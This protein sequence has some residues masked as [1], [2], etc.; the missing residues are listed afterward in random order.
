MI[1]RAPT[2]QLR[3]FTIYCSVCKKE[4]GIR[5]SENPSGPAKS[6]NGDDKLR[7]LAKETL[8]ERMRSLVDACSRAPQQPQPQQQQPPSNHPPP[9]AHRRHESSDDDEEEAAEEEQEESSAAKPWRPQR[10]PQFDGGLDDSPVEDNEESPIKI[11]LSPS[12]HARPHHASQHHY[13]RVSDTRVAAWTMKAYLDPPPM[14]AGWLVEHVRLDQWITP[15]GQSPQCL[16]QIACHTEH[17]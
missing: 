6:L 2:N 8:H 15:V 13:K 16:A 5:A 7:A 9:P 10:L 1:A 17:N 3:P 12:H 14:Y 11:L 4:A